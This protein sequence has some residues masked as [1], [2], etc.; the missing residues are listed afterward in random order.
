MPDP[1]YVPLTLLAAELDSGV[2]SLSARLGAQITR[3][4]TGFR[5]VP[6]WVAVELLAEHAARQQTEQDRLA[7]DRAARAAQ[8]NLTRERVRAIRRAQEQA[9][10]QTADMDLS[11]AA[12]ATVA[13]DHYVSRQQASGDALDEMLRGDMHYHSTPKE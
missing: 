7:R 10:L 6:A 2:R 1:D 5:V 4:R 3:D 11:A 8:P 12:L 9:G 13:V